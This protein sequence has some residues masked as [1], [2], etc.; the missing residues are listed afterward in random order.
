MKK[1]STILSLLLL[2]PGL[3]YSQGYFRDGGGSGSGSVSDTAYDAGTW[4]GVTTTAPSKNA[5]R[6]KIETLGGGHD[7]ATVTGSGLTISGQTISF[8]LQAGTDYIAPAG[9]AT[10][11]NVTITGTLS[12]ST[13]GSATLSSVTITGTLSASTIAGHP[14]ATV[15]GSGLTINGQTIAF[16]LQAGT[17]Y[18]AP[19]GNGSLLTGVVTTE[20]DPVAAAITGLIKGTGSGLSAS[21]AGVD[22]IA[23][24]ALSAIGI[25][26]GATHLGTFTG[27][28]ISDNTNVK[29]ALQEL[30]TEIEG[31][32]G[33]HEAAT[34]T[35]SGLT[36]SGQ[37]ISFSNTTINFVL[38]GPTSGGNAAPA[39]RALVAGDVPWAVPGAIGSTT[40]AA[41]TFTTLTATTIYAGSTISAVISANTSG[42]ITLAASTGQQEGLSIDLAST[43]NMAGISSGTGVTNVNFGSLILSALSFIGSGSLLTGVVT[44]E[45]DP[46]AAAITGLIKGTGSG[47]SAS[48][49]GV[50][51]VAASALSA[52]GIVSGA[53]HLGTFTGSIIADSTDVKSALQALE[54]AGHSIATVTGSGLTI[55]GQT[56]SFSATTI[57]FVLSGPTTGGNAVPAFR[58][59]VT[60]DIPWASPGTI[61][62]SAAS[63]GTFT[64][65][66]ATTIAASATGVS[67]SGSNGGLTI[68]GTG[69]G[70]D[71]NLTFDFNTTA[72]TVGVASSTGVATISF[73][74]IALKADG[75]LPD[76]ADGA[77][78][79]SATAEFSDLY[80]ADGG[81][82]YFQNDQSVYLTPSAAT[83]TL[84]GTFATTAGVTVGTS[85]LPDAADGATIG[86]AAAEWSDI[87]LADGSVIYFGNDQD[88]TLTHVPDAGL[89]LNLDLVIAGG[90]ITLISSAA[91]AK[92]TG[93]D[94]TITL[95]GTG[96][97][98]DE[99]L[100]LDFNATANEV[101]VSSGTGATK[102]NLGSL[103][104]SSTGIISGLYGVTP[105]AGSYTLGT[106]AEEVRGYLILFT[107]TGTLTLPDMTVG[108]SFCAMSR[109]DNEVVTID[110]H[111]NDSITLC[112]TAATCVKGSGGATI[113]NTVSASDGA[114]NYICFVVVEA[115]N[116][117]QWGIRGTWAVP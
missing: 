92:I 55:S 70:Q 42:V 10:L 68:A 69:D 88:V 40:P 16:T 109:D 43:T 13:L 60:G 23:A 62:S 11:S 89:S 86:S 74:T 6:D 54:T 112:P 97:G 3:A 79:G 66:T 63:T 91:G 39:F 28:I 52:L 5:V 30:E 78:L 65:L 8:T 15:T 117:M 75:F 83:L 12:A 37:T 4:D 22:Y 85:L 14:V 38:S 95:A 18:L 80:L 61:G 1:W 98:Q 116:I 2:L 103:A 105:T 35:G 64:T 47:L 96:S 26:S 67:L 108:Q 27:A 41:G 57:N 114:G 7:P 110:A 19:N 71:E 115:D 17:D 44:T 21:T 111:A 72:N 82:I 32:P 107:G 24:S 100:V 45:S 84:T 58:A 48:T 87:Y 101:G 93:G 81:V 113:V 49:A 50:D 51:Y 33:G 31:L 73:S 90:D 29:S 59:L 9:S 99:N 53:T 77:A 102:I 46:V 56:I 34:V 36:I 25:V 104:L 76:T 94:G 20:S 106:I